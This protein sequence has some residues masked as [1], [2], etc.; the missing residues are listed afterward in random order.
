MEFYTKYLKAL[1]YNKSPNEKVLEKIDELYDKLQTELSEYSRREIKLSIEINKLLEIYNRYD[2][3][4]EETNIDIVIKEKGNPNKILAIFECKHPNNNIEMVSQDNFN[5]KAFHEIIT[6]LFYLYKNKKPLPDYLVITNFLQWYIFKTNHIFLE[7]IGEEI[8]RRTF[9]LDAQAVLPFDNL[10]KKRIYENLEH[11]FNTDKGKEVLIRLKSKCL[12]IVLDKNFKFEEFKKSL[13]I[14]LS[15]DILLK[16]FDPNRGNPLKKDFYN[17]LLYIFGLQE[18]QINGKP[19]IV[20]NNVPGTFYSQIENYLRTQG[21]NKDFESILE[22]IIV[23]LNRILFLKLFETKLVEINN[24]NNYY[25]FL[26]IDKITDTAKLNYL[27]FQVLACPIAN[28]IDRTFNYVPYLN[29]TLFEIKEIENELCQ[30]SDIMADVEIPYYQHTVLKDN[31][32]RRLRGNIKLL[33]Y[34]FKFLD[35]YKFS[36]EGEEEILISPNVLGLVFEKINGYKDGSYYTPT[37]ITDY[38]TKEAICS[39][40]LS[41]IKSDL[42]LDYNNIDDLINM[43]P[44][45]SNKEREKIQKIIQELTII[46]PAVGSGHFLVSALNTLLWL[47][48]KFGMIQTFGK[49]DLSFEGGEISYFKDNETFHYTKNSSQEDLNFQKTIFN[50]KRHIIENNLFGVD[51][52]P[53]S[54]EIARLRLWIELLKHCYYITDDEMQTLPNIDINIKTGDALLG[55]MIN[56][57]PL[58]VEHDNFNFNRYKEL[59]QKYKEERG[60][61]ERKRILKQL[62]E[63]ENIIKGDAKNLIFYPLDFPHIVSEEGIGFDIVIGNPP[64]I[65]TKDVS[66]KYKKIL[67]KQFGFADDLYSHFYFKGLQLLKENGILAFIS[68]KTFWTIQTKKNLRELLLKNQILQLV[69]TANPFDAPMVD[70]CIAIVQKTQAQNYEIKFID[71]KQKQIYKVKD[72]VYKNVANK[73]FFAPTKL[74]LKIYEKIGTTVKKLIDNWWDKIS[75]SKNIEKYKNILE[76]YRNSLKPGD[77][78]LLGL[79]TEGGQGLATANN[80]KYIGVLEGTKLATKVKEERPKKLWEFIQNKNPEELSNLDT[81]NKVKKHLDNL[82]EKEIRILFDGLKERYGR[83]IFG[84]G[85]LYRIVSQD[86]IADIETLTDDEKLNGIEGEKTFV[87]YDKGD[88]EGNRWWAPTPYYIDWSRENVSILKTDPKARWQGYQFYFKEGF[89]WNLINATRSSV[90]L[91]VR[92]VSNSIYDVGSMRLIS[93][94]NSVP[95][96]FIVCILNSKLENLYAELFLNFTLNFQ[97]NDARQL[98]IIIPTPEQL[99][100]FEL[101]FDRAK[102]VQEEKFSGKINESEAEEKLNEI[103]KELDRKVIKLYRLIN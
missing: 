84:Q 14:F 1:R 19:V 3:E 69:D 43:F 29:S 57:K 74:N 68:S 37:Y 41:K 61:A 48:Y 12:F 20:P 13:A 76:T 85:W 99:K 45:L 67:I 95:N 53:K 39:F 28:R 23:W 81:E 79:I 96:S 38:M 7:L 16:E 6:N 64:Y 18:K 54:V 25:K 24:S 50:A 42:N 11:Y 102:R 82:T 71:T 103:Q 75:T 83:D 8:I 49:Y 22:L 98:P 2:I 27:F 5:K 80:G 52:N 47:W 60:K 31:R 51:I 87:P 72:T 65:S 10:T 100:E 35:Y 58:F 77:I 17:E 46:D 26:T 4:P 36:E 94:F 44:R 32:N 59:Y 15:P 88:K 40:I 66:P 90:D 70:T 78:T 55:I 21:E 63:M 34:L 9:I 101:I 33:E 93:N 92:W 56:P 62:T 86:E 73:V 89:C 91:R 30:I 97:I